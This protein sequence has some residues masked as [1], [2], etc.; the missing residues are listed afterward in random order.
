MR[1]RAIRPALLAFLLAAPLTVAEAQQP[2]GTTVTRQQLA[3]L[4]WIGGY[5]VGSGTQSTTQA[6]FHERYRFFGD[7]ILVVDSFADSTFSRVT[8]TARYELRDGRFGNTGSGARWVLSRIDGAAVEFAPA[9]RVT[10]GFRWE[11]MTVGPGPVEQWQ[12]T[13]LPAPGRGAPRHYL[14]RRTAPPADSAGVRAAAMD[15]IEGFYEG[16]STKHLRSVRPEVAKSGFSIPRDSS[17]YVRQEMTWPQFLDFTRR[18]RAQGRAPSPNWPKEVI[19]YDI[20]D[21]VA[22]VKVRAYWGIDYLLMARF[23]GKWM[24]THVLWQTPSPLEAIRR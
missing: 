3:Q 24:V 18:V 11:R 17:Q 19:I 15:Y 23:D 6:P 13:I 1:M 21:Q 8:E 12:A 4:R 16:D 20:L 22:S 10:S 5:W 7:S 2:V 14:M 9:E